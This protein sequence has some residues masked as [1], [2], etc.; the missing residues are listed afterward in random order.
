MKRHL[1]MKGLW[2]VL[3]MVVGVG[4]WALAQ[5]TISG[6]V[7]DSKT[8]ETLIG[9]TIYDTISRKGTT[10]NQHGRYSLTLKG[11]KA[12]LRVSFVGCERQYIALELKQSQ[13][14][15]VKLVSS[16][17]LQEVVVR[18]ERVQHVE[19]SQLSVVELPVEQV[20]V[21]PMIFGETDVVKAAQLLPGVQNGAEGMAGMYV[22]GGGPDENLFLL[23][24][25][26]MY[27]VNHL[28]G[29]F[30]AFNSDAVKNISLY[31]GSF[32]ARF[33][34][35]LSS[36]LDITTNDGNDKE[37]HGGASIGLISA[38]FNLEGPIVKER[39]TFSISGRRTYGDILLQP[40]LA[41]TMSASGEDAKVTAG[42][43]FYDINAKVTHRFN[44]R[45]RL[46][47]SYYMGDDALYLRF[48]EM[49][50]YDYNSY[51]RMGYYWGNIVGSLRWNYELTPKLFMN[52]SAAYTRYRSDLSAS[53]ELESRRDNHTE[54]LQLS[55]LS[56]IRD[57]LACA[58]FDYTPTPDHVVKFGT[59]YPFHYFT[60]E[61]QSL[62]YNVIN[63]KLDTIIGQST[64]GAHEIMLYAEDDWRIDDR[65]KVNVGLNVTG[66]AVEDK[67]YPSVQPR[68]SGR[69]LINDRLSAKVGYARMT[70]YLHLLSTNNISLPTDLWVPVTAHI[71]PMTSNQ[72]AAGLFYNL[73]D[74]LNLSVEGYYKTMDNLLEYRDGASFWGSSQGWE[75][76]VCMG[77]GWAY[78]VEFLA[79]KSVGKWTG[80][81]GY[82]WSRTMRLFDRDGMTLND[83]KPFPAKY[84]RRHD[85]S[86]VLTYKFS[87]HFDASMTWVFATGNA[88]TLAL[89]Q[90][91]PYEEPATR[92]DDDYYGDD[93]YNYYYSGTAADYVSS[94][95]NYRLPN[96][97]R[98][99]VSLNWHKKLRYGARTVNVSVYNVYNRQNPYLLYT[100]YS[101]SGSRT[102][103]Q[104]SI[105]PILPT[106]SYIWTF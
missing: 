33:G 68:V 2:I 5:H 4:P 98:M 28:G 32:P 82:T 50:G 102:L 81:I 95:N 29:F 10:T 48:K 64:V 99:D 18:G 105:F 79:Q 40:I 78:G 25:V 93:F 97:H 26:P 7:T 106:V 54:T 89:Q 85:V 36:V 60:P 57:M 24:G 3:L 38:K 46:Y 90:F 63:E 49:E 31:K 55:F 44:D 56:G 100:G 13:R 74:S 37:L 19:S 101:Y 9:A 59:H 23:D 86:I 76:K 42:Y 83:G 15:D 67:F 35:R 92:L 14:L 22:R 62:K 11:D 43:Y 16:Y 91:N 34:S 104:V 75:Q 51:M 88:T 103:N 73:M 53:E 6:T 30:S 17:T 41:A 21:I 20:K 84:D 12:V 58:D 27:N 87:D 69:W 72:V 71:T 39:T 47:A 66:F 45:S 61:T 1:K 96:Y 8:G 77:R 94:R 70:Q 65:F 80:W 52:L